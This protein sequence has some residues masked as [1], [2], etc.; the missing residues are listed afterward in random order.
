MKRPYGVF[1]NGLLMNRFLTSSMAQR[2]V[3]S[4]QLKGITANI[5]VI[6]DVLEAAK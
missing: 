6:G 5:L 1:V 2:L 4:F 3:K